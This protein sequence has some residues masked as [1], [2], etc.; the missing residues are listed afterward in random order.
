MPTLA[1]SQC[2]HPNLCRWYDYAS[3]DIFSQVEFFLLLSEFKKSRLP[4]DTPIEPPF[5]PVDD[6]SVESS[7]GVNSPSVDRGGYSM[8][9][10][11]AQV[12]TSIRRKRKRRL[13]TEKKVAD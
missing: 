10:Q 6:S 13:K 12:M 7:A 8:E 11:Q 9:N 1:T 2:L 3:D 4:V 5:V